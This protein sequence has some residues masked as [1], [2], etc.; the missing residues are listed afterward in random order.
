MLTLLTCS[1][2]WIMWFVTVGSTLFM[3]L[4]ITVYSFFESVDFNNEVALLF[5]TVDFLFTVAIAVIIALSEYPRQKAPP[6]S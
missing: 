5:S 6:Y 3:I 2:T 1:W 4:W